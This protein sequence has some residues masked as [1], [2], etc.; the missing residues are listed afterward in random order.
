VNPT[1][2]SVDLSGYKIGDAQSKGVYEGMY[3][4]PA[5]TI[6]PPYQALVIA[7][8]AAQF[9][10]D[11]PGR[12]PDFEFYETDASVP[13]LQPYPA[14]GAGEW[15]L[16]NEGDEVVLLGGSDRAVDVVVYGNGGFPGVAPHPGVSLWSHSLE[17][18][19]YLFD[20]DDCSVDFRDWPFPNPGELP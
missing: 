3:R 18:F 16:S 14:W 17:R 13:T 7:S 5:G 20:S 1:G 10:L 15:Y 4:F 6:L 8:S 9:R 11:Y 12:V 2:V 19:P